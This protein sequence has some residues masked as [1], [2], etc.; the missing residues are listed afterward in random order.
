ASFRFGSTKIAGEQDVIDGWATAVGDTID[1]YNDMLLP[2]IQGYRV[3]ANAKNK[4]STKGFTIGMNYFLNQ[5]IT[6]NGNYSWNKL[7]KE[8]SDDPIIPAYNTPE[9]K[10]NIGFT[11][12]DLSIISNSHHWGFSINYKWVEGFIFEGSPQFTGEVPDYAQLDAQIN[13]EIPS[14]HATFKVGASNLLNNLTY[15]VY[16]GPRVGRMM[17][18]SLQFDIN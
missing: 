9:H 1:N 2:S 11:A 3:A 8:G 17:Y 6:I 14:I 10:Y 16:G 5:H 18:A 12:R 13:K 15:Q 4:V 7:N